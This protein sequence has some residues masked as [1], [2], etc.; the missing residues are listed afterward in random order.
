MCMPPLR[1]AGD[2]DAIARLH[3]FHL[4]ADFFDHAHAGVIQ[5]HRL[6]II[7]GVERKRRKRIARDGGLRANQDLARLNSQQLQFLDRDAIAVAHHRA[8]L[9]PGGVGGAWSRL[10]G[11]REG[12]SR[13]SNGSTLLENVSPGNS[14]RHVNV[15]IAVTVSAVSARLRGVVEPV[16]EPVVAATVC[17]T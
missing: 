14:R 11:G 4:R 9:P 3:P 8:K 6:R 2:D 15:I 10:L 12:R 17:A 1:R 13:N 7:A 5:D 16:V